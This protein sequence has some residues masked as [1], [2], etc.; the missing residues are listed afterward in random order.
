MIDQYI[1]L[2]RRHISINP[3]ISIRNQEDYDYHMCMLHYLQAQ[4]GLGFKPAYMLTMHYQH[5]IEHGWILRETANSY[6]FK[7]RYGFQTK[8][9]IWNEVNLYK[10]FE[11]R[12]KDLDSIVKD[13]GHLRN[14]IVQRLYGI[15]RVNQTW[16]AGFPN[17]YIFHEM[18]KV[19]LQFHTHIII[20]ENGLRASDENDLMD[21]MNTSIKK[22]IQCLSSWKSIHVR[23]IYNAWGIFSYLNKESKSQSISMDFMNSNPI[24]PQN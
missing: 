21:I 10:H 17:F 13:A 8:R 5:P 19:K 9:S 6:G 7:D 1:K 20:P 15:S 23:K 22:R 2:H 14:L 4:M 12:R 3:S 24:I 16:K 11:K 18:G